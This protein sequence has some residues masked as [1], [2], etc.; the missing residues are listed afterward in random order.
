MEI[1]FP[2]PMN[3]LPIQTALVLRLQFLRCQQKSVKIVLN[4][5]KH[6]CLLQV[7]SNCTPAFTLDFH[8]A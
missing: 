6:S 1:P 8:K 3:F 7:I 5:I 4:H 2:V